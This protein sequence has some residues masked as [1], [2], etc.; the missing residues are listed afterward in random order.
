[1]DDIKHRPDRGD[2]Q[3]RP[4]RAIPK[5][6]CALQRLAESESGEQK[7][8][9]GFAVNEGCPVGCRTFTLLKW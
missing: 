4:E 3:H 2:K 9:L 7:T 6:E 1:M 5:H 8:R